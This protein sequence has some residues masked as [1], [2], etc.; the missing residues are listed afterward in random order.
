MDKFPQLLKLLLQKVAGAT[1]G[2]GTAGVSMAPAMV[3]LG[4]IGV[5]GYGVYKSVVTGRKTA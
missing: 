4:G 5:G 2:L 1:Q 3:A